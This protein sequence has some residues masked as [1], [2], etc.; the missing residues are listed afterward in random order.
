[1]MENCDSTRPDSR[2]P[3][4]IALAGL[5]AGATMAAAVSFPKLLRVNM[6]KMVAKKLKYGINW[7]ERGSTQPVPH[8][9]P[10]QVKKEDQRKHPLHQKRQYMRLAKDEQ[11]A[12]TKRQTSSKHQR[13]SPAPQPKQPKHPRP[14][15]RPQRQ[16]A[17]L[18]AACAELPLQRCKRVDQREHE[19]EHANPRHARQHP[20]R[21]RLKL[22]YRLH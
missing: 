10:Y 12:C 3:C 19:H 5:I 21:P 18:P 20:M 4:P 13:P 22:F 11:I 16:H 2:A 14:P 1:M 17:I 6:R 9:N 8:L 15:Q 7:A